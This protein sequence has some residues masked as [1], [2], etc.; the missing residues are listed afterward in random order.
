MTMHLLELAMPLP[1]R[2]L[3]R[4]L[5]TATLALH[6]CGVKGADTAGGGSGG[7]GGS[8]TGDDG[9]TGTGTGT[10]GEGGGTGGL[11]GTGDGGGTGGDGEG[12]EPPAGMLLVDGGTFAIGN[13]ADSRWPE[14]TVTLTHDF[15]IDIYETTQF[16]FYEVMGYNPS[17]ALTSGSDHPVESVSWHEAAAF[18]NAKSEAEGLLACYVCTG[19]APTVECTEGLLYDCPGYRLPTDAEF[20]VAARCGDWESEFAGTDDPLAVGFWRDEFEGHYQTWPVGSFRANDC[21]IHDMSCNVAEWMADWGPTGPGEDP[22]SEAG[23]KVSWRGG[24]WLSD[25]GR[26]V[27]M[28]GV[29]VM[30]E[31]GRFERTQERGFRLVRS[32]LD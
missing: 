13:G 28:T 2:S 15:Y 4:L 27:Q 24:C 7:D 1:I 32:K 10:A 21:G 30:Y 5:L 16:K 22:Y 6:G 8:G 14:R 19:D 11:S 12:S 31:V 18:A 17:S 29:Y 3:L 20:E 9:G 23:S 25:G 26:I